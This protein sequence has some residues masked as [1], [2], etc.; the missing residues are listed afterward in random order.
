MILEGGAYN[1]YM[2]W[3]TSIYSYDQDIYKNDFF[4]KFQGIS[5]DDFFAKLTKLQQ[6]G[7]VEE[8]THD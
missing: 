2:C 8:F 7:D 6:K 4:K 5:K 1:W 3:K